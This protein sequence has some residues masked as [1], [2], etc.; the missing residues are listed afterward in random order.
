MGLNLFM[1]L[2]F[3]LL[4]R[5]GN[6]SSNSNSH[7]YS[8]SMNELKATEEAYFNWVHNVGSR[9]HSLFEEAKN[10]FTVCKRIK[11]H[12]N[13]KF[14]DY[15]SVQKAIDSVPIVNNC[16]V[17]ISVSAGIY[18]YRNQFLIKFSALILDAV[19]YSF[20]WFLNCAL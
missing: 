11:V 3:L 6:C 19:L 17:V 7:S 12:K 14:G 16:R 18:R 5:C 8:L 13:P 1:L 10:K 4:F 20:G 15:T 2:L 9:N